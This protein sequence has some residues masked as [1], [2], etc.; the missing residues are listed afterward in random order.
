MTADEQGPEGPEP[1]PAPLA[2]RRVLIGLGLGAASLGMLRRLPTGRPA[3]PPSSVG[4]HPTTSTFPATSTTTPGRPVP[5][6]PPVLDDSLAVVDDGHV[7]DVVISGGRVIDPD[8]HFD[9]VAHVGIDGDTITRISL[10]PLT[11]TTTVDAAGLVVSPG[12]IDILSYP[13]NGYG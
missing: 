4:P 5:D 10:E 13:T 2:R 8:S 1:G 7:H 12:F 3:A 9:A 6:V 11:G